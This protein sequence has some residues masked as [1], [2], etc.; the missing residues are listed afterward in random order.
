MLRPFMGKVSV[1]E[2]VCVCV[3]VC[4]CTGVPVS[5]PVTLSSEFHRPTLL[6]ATLKCSVQPAPSGQD[7]KSMMTAPGSKVAFAV[8]TEDQTKDVITGAIGV[9]AKS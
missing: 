2:W 1:C 8:R 3:C 6:P 9:A 5:A 7:Y 4:V